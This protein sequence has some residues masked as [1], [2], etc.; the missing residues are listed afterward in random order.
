[1]YEDN[2]KPLP[3]GDATTVFAEALA[4]IQRAVSSL[5]TR[6]I[7]SDNVVQ[8]ADAEVQRGLEPIC[9]RLVLPGSGVSGALHLAEL[10]RLAADRKSC[11]VCL[12]HR[13]NLDVPTLQLL[14]KDQ[15]QAELFDRM[16][17]IAGRKLSEDAGLTGL[18]IQACHRLVVTPRSWLAKNHSADEVAAGHRINVAAHR[19][20]HD[21][22]HAGW[23]FGLF[24][25]GTRMRGDDPSTMRALEE[26]D[27]YLRHFDFMMLGRIDGCTLPVRRDSDMTHEIPALDCVRYT[28]GEVMCTEDWRAKAKDRFPELLG[29]AATATAIMQDIAAL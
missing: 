27:T 5:P 17:W 10:V 25:S 1:M 15:G 6:E 13:S 21:L 16:V 4:D 2:V 22:R 12:N 7:T 20:M 24:P 18:L 3:P 8:W 14:L 26:T 29:R 28:F 23:V 11:I 9:R 19:A